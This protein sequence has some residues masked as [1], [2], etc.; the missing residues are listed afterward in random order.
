[1]AQQRL[2][3]LQPL[4]CLLA[5]R[6]EEVH[7]EHIRSHHTIILPQDRELAQQLL[8]EPTVSVFN[9]E[10][11]AVEEDTLLTTTVK[12]VLCLLTDMLTALTDLLWYISGV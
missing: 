2:I 9:M 4:R 11:T 8:C 3:G 6:L 10:W 5:D 12:E 7:H 1:M